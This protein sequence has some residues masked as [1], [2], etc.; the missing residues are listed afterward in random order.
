MSTS[1]I[2]LGTA[3]VVWLTAVGAGMAYLAHYD[4]QPGEFLAAPAVISSLTND[5]P[6][7]QRLL[8]FVHPRCPCSTASLRELERLM[9]RCIPELDATI[10]F[11]RPDNEPDTWA[12][13]ALWDM[14]CHMPGVTTKIDA[15]GKVA[16]QFAATTSGSIVVYDPF[17]N[18]QFQGGITETRGHEGDSRGKAALF[19]IAR[20]EPREDRQCPVYGCPLHSKSSSALSRAGDRP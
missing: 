14:A 6:Q 3:L 4:R 10:Y 12:H 20:G 1:R 5:P 19:A 13:G 18:L 8:M 2:V 9:S 16:R 17:G 11:I 7:K 15:G